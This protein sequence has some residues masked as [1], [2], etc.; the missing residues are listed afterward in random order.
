MLRAGTPTDWRDAII[1]RRISGEEQQAG[2]P[3]G[4]ILRP[5]ISCGSMNRAQASRPELA[6]VSSFM[7]RLSIWPTIGCATRF[8]TMAF[9]SG[10]STTL[11]GNKP[12]IPR[13]EG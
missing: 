11:P 5:T 2:A 6:P 1:S 3:D 13:A 12:G 9:D 4:L 7:A 8:L 10:T